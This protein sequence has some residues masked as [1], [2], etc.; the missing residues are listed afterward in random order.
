MVYTCLFF[1]VIFLMFNM[2]YILVSDCLYFFVLFLFWRFL[3]WFSFVKR[4]VM[5]HVMSMDSEGVDV[6][7]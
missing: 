3:G 7:D 1:C 6:V 4:S 2:S 5:F